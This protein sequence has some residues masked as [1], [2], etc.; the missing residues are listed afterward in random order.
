MCEVCDG[1]GWSGDLQLSRFPHS[2][3][4]PWP[5]TRHTGD[6]QMEL[7]SC[8]HFIYS[9]S[10][11]YQDFYFIFGCEPYKVVMLLVS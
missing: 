10:S 3:A 8:N 7:Y 9:L 11:Y 5:P 1:G 4:A 2:R 6:T